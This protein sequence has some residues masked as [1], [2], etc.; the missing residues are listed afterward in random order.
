MCD[1]KPNRTNSLG[2]TPARITRRDLGPARVP[3]MIAQPYDV[4]TAAFVQAT[5]IRLKGQE[6]TRTPSRGRPEA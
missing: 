2:R 3:G 1:W 5:H 6:R 4:R